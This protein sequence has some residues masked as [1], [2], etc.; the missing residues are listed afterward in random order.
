M[1]QWMSKIAPRHGQ[2]L[3]DVVLWRSLMKFD[4]AKASF[5]RLS[6]EW[7]IEKACVQP[8]A[9]SIALNFMG[10]E[11]T[12]WTMEQDVETGESRLVQDQWA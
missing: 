9:L 11:A 6:K 8:G 2:E 7:V 3:A 4:T 5:L 10:L 1:Q 12:P